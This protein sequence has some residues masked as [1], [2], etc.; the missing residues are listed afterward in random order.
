MNIRPL[1][2]RIIVQRIEEGEQKIG[3]I[4]IPDA[5]TEKPVHGK[6]IAVG[7]GRVQEEGTIVPL[8]VKMGTPSSSESIRAPK[9]MSKGRS[10]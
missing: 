9:W 5:A 3:G 2:D 4:I 6:A 7:A 10:T 8:D 1:R